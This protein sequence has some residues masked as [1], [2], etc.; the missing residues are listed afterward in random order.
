MAKLSDRYFFF[1]RKVYPVLISSVIL[2]IMPFFLPASPVTGADPEPVKWLVVDIPSGG[3][4]GGWVLAE[5][6]LCGR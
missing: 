3:E 5:A 1:K 4:T 6:A 2:T